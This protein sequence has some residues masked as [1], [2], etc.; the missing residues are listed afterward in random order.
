M[1]K[2]EMILNLSLAISTMCGQIVSENKV[3]SVSSK[4]QTF[5]STNGDRPKYV[6][7]S[8]HV[9]STIIV[10][11][12]NCRLKVLIRQA[13][14]QE[15]RLSSTLRQLSF[16][17]ISDYFQLNLRQH[18]FHMSCRSKIA[19]KKRL[20]TQSSKESSER[21]RQDLLPQML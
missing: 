12:D 21:R 18:L 7:N 14:V 3:C 17:Q 20:V 13:C 11:I 16:V 2:R 6:H 19:Q 9:K 15:L 10:Y 4:T 5:V 8:I 1:C